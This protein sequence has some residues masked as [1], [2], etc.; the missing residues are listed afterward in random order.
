[1]QQHYEVNNKHHIPQPIKYLSTLHTPMCAL[2]TKQHGNS[3]NAICSLIAPALTYCN[4][5][6]AS[7]SLPY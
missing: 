1:M 3:K 2:L 4:E 6:S 5:A 7:L